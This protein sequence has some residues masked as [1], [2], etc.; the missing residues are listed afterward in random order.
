MFYYYHN[1]SSLILILTL[2]ALFYEVMLILCF[3]CD[4]GLGFRTG[5]EDEKMKKMI[6]CPATVGCIE[7]CVLMFL[8]CFFVFNSILLIIHL[9][10]TFPKQKVSSF[11]SNVQTSSIPTDNKNKTAPLLVYSK[12]VH[13]N[14]NIIVGSTLLLLEI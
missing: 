7:K 4:L 14:I 8:I 9:I 13:N 12:Y 3:W 6:V 2:D 5:L 1:A 11:K 10:F